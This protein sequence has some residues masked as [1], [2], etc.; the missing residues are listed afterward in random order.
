[1][2]RNH[3]LIYDQL[4]E[5]APNSRPWICDHPAEAVRVVDNQVTLTDIADATTRAATL[6][7]ESGIR[8]GDYCAVWLDSPLDIMIIVA[9][10]TG[11]GGV[12]ILLSP[13]LDAET[14]ARMLEPVTVERIITTAD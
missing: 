9:A 1:M 11:V 5:I 3:N 14:L 4:I 12:P 8:P 2:T 7:T 6:F 13:A 10:L